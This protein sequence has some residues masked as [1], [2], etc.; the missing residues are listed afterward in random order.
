MDEVANPL[1]TS[2]QRAIEDRALELLDHP[3]VRRARAICAVLWKNAT[4]WTSRD[5]ADRFDTMIDEYMFHHAMRAANGDADFP[6]VAWFMTPQHCWFGREVPGSR[7]AGDSPDFIYRT[8]P[9]A[10]GGRYEIYGKPSCADPP[11]VNYSLMADNRASPVT[12][13]LLDSLDMEFEADGS[14][15]ITVDDT[16]ADCQKNHIQTRPGADFIMVRDALGDWLNQ[17]ANVLTVKRLDPDGGPKSMDEMA[18]HCA[19]IAVDGVYY[20]YY[21]TQ[22]GNGYPPNEIRPPMSSGAFGGM[23]SQWGTKANLSLEEDEALII[24]CNAAGAQFRNLVLTDAFHLSIEYWKRT[25]SLNMV[26]MAPDEDG[27]FTFV[28]A[29]RD[30]GIHNWLDTGGL[31]RTMFGHR[32]QAFERGSEHGAPWMTGRLVKFDR[33]DR[34]LSDGVRRIDEAGR[35]AQI[36]AREEGVKRRFV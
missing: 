24:R 31:K 4:G 25:S 9:I 34:E 27:D 36:G 32:W 26:Q 10:H 23:A 17:S 35:K 30:P 7:W 1:A 15:T 13:A 5:Q 2:A 28:I 33:L 21:V 19:G 8:I 20:S 18:R 29:A 11:T 14:F 6:E 22:T 12:Q 16:P 3:D